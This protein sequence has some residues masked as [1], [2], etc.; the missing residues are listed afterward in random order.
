[1]INY[2]YVSQHVTTVNVKE[3]QKEKQLILHEWLIS[4]NFRVH[5]NMSRVSK[6]SF[7]WT[8]WKKWI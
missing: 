8:T 4:L 6:F 5:Y 7:L 3:N 1:V 2:G